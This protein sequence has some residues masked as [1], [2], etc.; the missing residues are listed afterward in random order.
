[1]NTKNFIAPF[2]FVSVAYSA[3]ALQATVMHTDYTQANIWVLQDKQQQ[4][5]SVVVRDAKSGKETSASD[6]SIDNATIT[7]GRIRK[8]KVNELSPNTKY[9]Y[10]VKDNQTQQSIK[11]SFTTTPDY[12]DR[13]PPPDF[14]F[15]VLGKNYEND[16]PFDVPFRTN[17]GEYEIFETVANTKP[18]FAIW[19]GGTDTL[20][21]AD[22]GSREAMLSR[23]AKSRMQKFAQK[24]LQNTSNYGVMASVSFG[25][26]NA[27]KYAP[28]AKNAKDA[29]DSF[30]VIPQK[31]GESFYYSFSYSD[32][33]IFVLDCCSQRSNLDYKE[34]MPKIL[35][36]EQIKWLMAN[37]SASKA[38][39]K[40]IVSNIPFA[41]PV[42][43]P[44]NFTFAEKERK[45]ILDFLALKKIEGIIFISANKNYAETTRLIRAGAY[46]LYEA[47]VGALTDRPANDVSEMNY[48][49]QPNSLI[50]KRSFLN[51]K[52]DGSENDRHITL[53]FI[54][55]KGIQAYSFTLKQ[56]DL[57]GRQ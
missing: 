11:G 8:I 2:I 31:N 35:G 57:Q 23:F 12:K 9:T 32:V 55:A 46:P 7:D 30:W 43:S 6:L 39:F 40:I 38:T 18:C 36:A 26:D 3:F 13:T 19:A 27:D 48:F 14:S 28:S 53:S 49:R 45:E 54:D 37:L 20:R 21:P 41:N 47:T 50:K 51:V 25:T 24:L 17:G 56:S 1:M 52:V 29:F 10:E 16:A 15:V 42:S 44:K 22:M 5:I 4:D 33:D 34:H